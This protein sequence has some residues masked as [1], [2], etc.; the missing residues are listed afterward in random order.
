MLPSGTSA[1]LPRHPA[2]VSQTDS[3]DRDEW[4]N[5]NSQKCTSMVFFL[6]STSAPLATHKDVPHGMWCSRPDFAGTEATPRATPCLGRVRVRV[7]SRL[8]ELN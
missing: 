8:I 2:P 3:E 5:S 7:H 4:N 6:R 1:F